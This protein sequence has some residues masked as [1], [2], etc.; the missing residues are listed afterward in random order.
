MLK[1]FNLTLKSDRL[2]ELYDFQGGPVQRTRLLNRRS[3][4]PS[5]STGLI[6]RPRLTRLSQLLTKHRLALVH[7]PAGSGK[8]T[9]L[10]Q[11]HR[12]LSDAGFSTVWYSA[13]ED[14][15]DPLSF[16]EGLLQALQQSLSDHRDHLPSLD[17]ADALQRLTALLT[18]QSIRQPLALFIDDYHL[19]E[20]GDGGEAINTI[21]ASRLPS[22]TVVL[23]SRN[24]PAIPVGRYRA[25]GEMID[26]AVE[27]LH[28]S[29][30]ET[31]AFFRTA[32]NVALTADE[33]RQMHGHTEGWAVGLRLAALV[34]GRATG[35]FVAAAPSGSHRAFADYFLEE[36]IAGLPAEV[37]DFLAKTSLL[38]TLNADLCNAVTGRRDGD[39]M[40]A[41]LEQSQLFVVELPG[42]QRWYKYHH[43]FQEFLQTRLYGDDRPAVEGIHARAA[44]WFIDNGSP[45][46]AVRHAFQARQSK[47]AAELI[48]TYCL[49]DYL[50]HGRFDTYS[51]W[52][53][54]LP[55]EAREERPLLLF[56]QVWRSINMRRFLQ[57]EQTLQ[58]I[59]AAASDP[60]SPVSLIAARTGLD[61]SG[62]LHLMRALIGAY[63]GDF[64]AGSFHLSQLAGKELDR[65]A[66][67]QVDLDSIHS[68][69]AFNLGKLDL[70]ER[71]TWRA[72]GVYDDMACHWGGIHSRC[73][74]AMSYIARALFQE[75]RHVI[76]EALAI[77]EQNFGEH[78]YMVALPSA[79]LGLIAYDDNDLEK[80]ERLWRRAIPAEKATDVSG[81]CERILIATTGLVRLLDITG[82]VEEATALLVRAS[83]RAYE[84]EDFRLEFQL[85]IERADRAFRLNSPA[86]GR[87]E[88]ERL[89]L[90]LPEARNRFP[91]SAWQIWDPFR[92]AE[93]RILVNAGQ[94]DAAAEKLRA[95][96]TG[97]RQEGRILMARQ[98]EAL[99][100]VIAPGHEAEGTQPADLEDDTMATRRILCDFVSPVAASPNPGGGQRQE[101]RLSLRGSLTEL[102]QREDDVLQLMR[103]GL[104]NSEIATKLDINLNTVKS[105]AKNIFAKLGVKSRTQAVLKTLE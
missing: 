36:V 96:A 87:R 29:E 105:H 82:R 50:S 92:I 86:E 12:G 6:D 60:N 21:L 17:R 74:A 52:M 91:S 31:E 65:L 83:R 9:L 24:R 28:F 51:R 84:A 45:V 37:C 54:Q 78:S 104:S 90:Q 81:L 67:G 53:Q 13:S 68:Y 26:I 39:R 70:A 11:W 5:A 102:T 33:S 100:T 46:D 41:F 20:G 97:A 14:D 47:W 25:N 62:R 27:D 34:T 56:L 63:G 101:A 69:F 73:I 15:K 43:L 49:Y 58:T 64:T 4:P 16:A 61:I 35:N 59:E 98:A 95:L 88:W 7:A 48:E 89:S 99:A 80:A 18:D 71:L 76:V 23:A 79:L 75:A 10:A 42:T 19:A 55:R 38:E 3:V 44:Q 77:A 94:I 93:A 72:N 103:W 8:T 66:F 32:S 85:G 40:L 1:F 30:E 22:L 2:G 57:A